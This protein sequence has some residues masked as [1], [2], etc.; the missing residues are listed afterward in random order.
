M[1]NENVKLKRQIVDIKATNKFI[2]EKTPKEEEY[3]NNLKKKNM[4]D[5]VI[6]SDQKRTKFYIKRYEIDQK[7]LQEQIDKVKLQIEQRK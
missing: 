6:D 3:E 2:I 5:S 4:I 1:Q 7:S